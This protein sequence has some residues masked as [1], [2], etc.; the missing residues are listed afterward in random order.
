MEYDQRRNQEIEENIWSNELANLWKGTW[1][2]DNYQ[3]PS[4]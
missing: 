1:Q 4:S 2:A 3:L